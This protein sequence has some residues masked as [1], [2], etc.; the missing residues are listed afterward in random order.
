MGIFRV[1]VEVATLG[2]SLAF[3][4]VG[5]LI[6]D[7]GPEVSWVHHQKLE[8]AG[9]DVR[10]PA[11]RFQMA[12][13]EMIERDVGYAILRAEGFETIDEVVFSQDDDLELLGAR[14]LE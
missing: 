12:N 13:G 11:Q 5:S 14:T 3:I 1:D 4:A 7:T 6:V 9:V 8:T 10:K 2:G